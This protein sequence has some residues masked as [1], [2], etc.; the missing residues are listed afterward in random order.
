M[1]DW[2]KYEECGKCDMKELEKVLSRHKAKAESW[3]RGSGSRRS[4]MAL[5][6]EKSE[7]MYGF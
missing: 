3:I 4:K 1:G 5:K 7:E 2:K 6:K